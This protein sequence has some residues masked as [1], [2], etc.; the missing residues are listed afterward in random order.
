MKQMLCDCG[1]NKSIKSKLCKACDRIRRI[2]TKGTNGMSHTSM[3]NR[4]RLM[5]RRC[6][7]EK[8]KRF[9]QYGGRGIKVCEQWHR[10]DNYYADMGDM[11]FLEAEVD[12]I[13]PDGNYEPSNCR[14]VTPQQNA[15][16]RRWGSKYRDTYQMVHIDKLCAMCKE[17]IFPIK[18]RFDGNK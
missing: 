7:D 13:D 6:Y 17:K 16:N 18:V 5:M 1:K 11:P 4:W 12:R 10:F 14:W 8:D 2:T 3:Y 15:G 9:F